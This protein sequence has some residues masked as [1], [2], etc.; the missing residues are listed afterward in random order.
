MLEVDTTRANIPTTA[1]ETNAEDGGAAD[2]A[3]EHAQRITKQ[4]M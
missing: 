1:V 4:I 3:A 2:K